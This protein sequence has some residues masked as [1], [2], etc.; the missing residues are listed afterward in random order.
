M[1]HSLLIFFSIL[2]LSACNQDP[3][4]P[5]EG[6]VMGYKPV[7]AKY[8]D[9]RNI[10]FENGK[11]LKNVGKIYVRGN[12]LFV[13]EYNQGIHII[14]NIDPKSPK[15]TAFIKIPGNQDIEMKNNI[16]YADNGLDLVALDFSNPENVKILK[17]I[18]NTFPYPSFPPFE[19]IK[20]ECVDES[21]GF[22]VSWEYVELESPKCSR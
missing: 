5:F 11:K 8:S 22:V 2:L 13:N 7:Y 4:F 16:M 17:R 21:K 6:K 14:N 19:N 12:Y 10:G 1:K 15:N 18:E 9:M 3:S 20:F